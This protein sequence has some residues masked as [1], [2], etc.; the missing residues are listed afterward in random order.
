MT[1]ILI[2]LSILVL[3]SVGFL[4]GFIIACGLNN[5]DEI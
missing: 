2:I 5:E 3:L 4:A 1:A